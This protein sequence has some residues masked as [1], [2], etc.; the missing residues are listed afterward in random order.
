[1]QTTTLNARFAAR[2]VFQ[3]ERYGRHRC[4]VHGE[5]EPMVE[6][7]DRNYCGHSWE[8]G[9]FSPIGQFVNRYYVST[10]LGHSSHPLD[11]DAGVKAWTVD[12]AGVA[13]LHK[14]LLQVLWEK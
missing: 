14:W 13:K 9:S 12:Q 1:M 2:L 10:I 11:L 7:Y 3:G 4:L 6:V 5:P 8:A